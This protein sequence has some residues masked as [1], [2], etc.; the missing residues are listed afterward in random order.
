MEIG[1]VSL[2]VRWSVI[3]WLRAYP[4]SIEVDC[5]CIA[6]LEAVRLREEFGIPSGLEILLSEG[7]DVEL[8]ARTSKHIFVFAFDPLS[9]NPLSL[10]VLCI[11]H[12][13]ISYLLVFMCLT[14]T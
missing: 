4:S 5:G 11:I 14:C 10:F 6:S 12:S 3:V 9:L 8:G 1:F 2:L 13:I 7:G